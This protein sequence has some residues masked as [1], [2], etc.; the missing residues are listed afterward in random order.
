M[1]F[2]HLHRSQHGSL[3]Q[4][5]KIADKLLNVMRL[6]Q[7]DVVLDVGSGDGYYSSRFAEFCQR[8][9]A[10]DEY[11]DGLKS[12]FYNK[13]NIETVCDDA[14]KWIKEHDLKK[15]THVFFSNSFHDMDC[16]NEILSGLS[17]KLSSG[18]HVDMI[19]F[20]PD[21]PFG[22]PRSIRFSREVLKSKVESNGFVEES[23]ID[24][25]THY[26]ISFKKVEN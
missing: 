3:E 25:G 20:Y 11:C 8:V 18:S 14:C 7:A 9:V 19:E 23:F 15:V 2:A 16:Q 13:P 6:S 22:P 17:R 24:M 12:D 10:I 21:T 1:N 26:F 4:K 5:S